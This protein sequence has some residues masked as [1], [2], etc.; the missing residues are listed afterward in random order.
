MAEDPRPALARVAEDLRALGQTWALVGGLAVAVRG[1]PRFT[2]DVDVA[3]AVDTDSAF[4]L[5]V[6]RL[7]Q[8]GYGIASVLVHEPTGRLAT[9]RLLSP[10]GSIVDLLGSSC[11]FEMEAVAKATPV[12]IPGVGAVPVVRAEELLAMKVLAFR[13]A[14][15][16]D[17]VDALGILELNPQLDLVSVR[18]TLALVSERGYDRGRDLLARLDSL[19]AQRA[20]SS[21][22]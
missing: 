17:R 6:H 14:R 1:E 20:D 10:A 15:P 5:L 8:R 4:E 7:Q 21:G 16:H 3:V 11:G 18:Q 2:R 22:S 13:P 12:Q 19:V 9:V